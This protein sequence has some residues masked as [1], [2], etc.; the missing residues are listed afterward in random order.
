MDPLTFQND[1]EFQKIANLTWLPWVCP[2]YFQ[3]PKDKRLLI[4]GES[5]Y[6]RPE[7]P[8]KFDE[9]MQKHVN[10]TNYTRDVVSQCL[11]HQ[12]W[13][14][15]TLDTIPRLLFKST[16]LDR[17]RFWEDTAYYNFIQTPMHYNKEGSPERPSWEAFVSGWGVFLEIVRL[18]QPSHCLFIGIEALNSFS[19]SMNHYSI[20]FEAVKCTEKVSRT[21]G[22]KASLNIDGQP[23]SLLGVQHLGK[24]FSWKKWN[25][26]LA[27][28]HPDL[29]AF[30][31]AESY[32]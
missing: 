14:N 31:N 27:T 23:I 2:S 29:M 21:Y 30:L 9:V 15:R 6:I 3:R 16:N 12:Y 4:I 11:I 32:T 7:S 5:H 18:L 24:Y 19:Y 26:Y 28:Q 13:K 22:R 17:A 1:I 20:D 8:D 25:N 10:D